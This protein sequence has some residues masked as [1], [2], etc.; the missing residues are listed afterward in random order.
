MAVAARWA[1]VGMVS[2]FVRT[3]ALPLSSLLPETVFTLA[4]AARKHPL[5]S[6]ELLRAVLVSAEAALRCTSDDVPSAAVGQFTEQ[7]C[8]D[9]FISDGVP[10]KLLK[11][12]TVIACDRVPAALASTVRAS[13]F[14]V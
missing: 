10:E 6:A 5:Q 2:L 4:Q 12:L 3:I 7:C 11:D 14:S 13:L 9:Y 8:L 1:A